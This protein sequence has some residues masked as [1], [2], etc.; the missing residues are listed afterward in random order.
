MSSRYLM[1]D[2]RASVDHAAATMS[3]PFARNHLQASASQPSRTT[4]RSAYQDSN[5]LDGLL[6]DLDKDNDPDE[7]C[8]SIETRPV[9]CAPQIIRDTSSD[10]I[11][12]SQ[13]ARAMKMKIRMRRADGFRCRGNH[14]LQR[15]KN[16]F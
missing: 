15:Q 13:K 9:R 16:F 7:V 6:I 3:S 12:I 8:E 1:R 5:L 10:I 2:E 4:A 11:E 14:M